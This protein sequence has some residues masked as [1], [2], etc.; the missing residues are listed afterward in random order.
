MD[1]GNSVKPAQ[2]PCVRTFH[3]K[4]YPRALMKWGY[5]VATLQPVYMYFRER[6]SGTGFEP[7]G[8][9]GSRFHISLFGR[10]QTILSWTKPSL[11][12]FLLP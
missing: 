10:Y 8:M 5:V 9:R 4:F 3:V 11:C 6:G 2:T 12:E 7:L 1:D